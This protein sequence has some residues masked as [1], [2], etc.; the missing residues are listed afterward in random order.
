VTSLI[1]KE[2]APRAVA[3]TPSAPRP[4]AAMLAERAAN[5]QG[6]PT[7]Q[8]A[9]SIV[10]AQPNVCELQVESSVAGARLY[11][12]GA[13]SGATPR[14]VRL[15]MGVHTVLITAP[16]YESW[17]QRFFAPPGKAAVIR[18]QLKPLPAQ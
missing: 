3:E 14:T 1:P 9:G 15:L 18:A 10:T 11:I 5:A 8:L 2:T 7:A 4:D 17:E 6:I 16:G 13:F 12:D